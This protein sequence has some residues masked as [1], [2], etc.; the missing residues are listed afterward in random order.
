MELNS[1]VCL[2][3]HVCMCVCDRNN[4]SPGIELEGILE[5]YLSKKEDLLQFSQA[6]YTGSCTTEPDI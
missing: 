4:I 6:S 2:Y 3:V 5:A 1:S